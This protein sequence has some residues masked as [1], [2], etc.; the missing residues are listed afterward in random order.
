MPWQYFTITF[1]SSKWCALYAIN[2][3]LYISCLIPRL[4][5][6]YIV[7]DKIYLI[8]VMLKMTPPPRKYS[9]IFFKT[10]TNMCPKLVWTTK[11]WCLSNC[12]LLGQYQGLGPNT[13]L[14]SVTGKYIY[15]VWKLTKHYFSLWIW[16]ETTVQAQIKRIKWYS[17]IFWRAMGAICLT[18]RCNSKIPY[19]FGTY[20]P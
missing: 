15:L 8:N 7:I 12:W 18:R 11:F 1:L 4:K 10:W 9:T 17:F 20:S 2:Y 3:I 5:Y 19:L 14:Q 6:S 16:F 13:S